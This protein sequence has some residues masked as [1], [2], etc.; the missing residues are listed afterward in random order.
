MQKQQI[1]LCLLCTC[2]SVQQLTQW[3]TLEKVRGTKLG[4]SFA[5][6]TQRQKQKFE[7]GQNSITSLYLFRPSACL[8]LCESELCCWKYYSGIAALGRDCTNTLSCSLIS[9]SILTVFGMIWALWVVKVG[10]HGSE[11]LQCF[12][13]IPDQIK[14]WRGWDWFGTLCSFLNVFFSRCGGVHCPAK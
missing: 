9:C 10:H 12:T 13:H 11:L 6:V 14:I 2:C 7:V 5:S 4:R 3:S 8:S 1:T